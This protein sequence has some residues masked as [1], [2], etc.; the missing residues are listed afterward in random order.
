MQKLHSL[1]WT[2]AWLQLETTTRLEKR[3]AQSARS[4]GAFPISIRHG[5]SAEAAWRDAALNQGDLRLDCYANPAR[6]PN[7]LAIP[8]PASAT[9]KRLTFRVALILS[10]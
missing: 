10:F 1:H 9:R 6:L 3:E 2:G 5:R 8:P 4:L 7:L